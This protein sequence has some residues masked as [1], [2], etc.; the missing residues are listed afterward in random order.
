MT[1]RNYS[2]LDRFLIHIEWG[3]TTLA[4]GAISQRPNPADHIP[5]PPLTKSER[6]ISGNMMRVNHTGEVCAQALYYGQMVMA[7]SDSIYQMLAQAAKEE[8]DHLSW[9]EQRLK[10]LNTHPSYLCAFWYSQAYLIGLVAGLAGDRW[11]LGFI[12]ETERQVTRH[13]EKH[14]GLLPMVDI[15]SRK[16]IT[17]MRDDENQHGNNAA[18]AGASSLPK[19]IQV[20]MRLHAKVMTSVAALV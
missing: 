6:R 7:R 13:L 8:T 19:I 2:T 5:E 3:L 16:I 9:T 14:L 15:K 20:L 17:Q 4:G 11:S 10:E 18:A 12:E 1:T